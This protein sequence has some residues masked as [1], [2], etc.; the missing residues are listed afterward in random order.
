MA[1]KVTIKM[2][3]D[4][5]GV[6][7]G[8]VDRVINGR[9]HVKAEVIDR[10]VAAM[11]ELEYAP[12]CYK[13]ALA[14]GLEDTSEIAGLEKYRL[15]VLLP[16]EGGHLRRELL[17]GI[18]DAGV[19]L[20]DYNVEVLGESCE[21]NLPEESIEK[22]DALL[23]KGV[24]GIALS[25]QDHPLIVQ[26]IN[27]ISQKGIA[28]IT[29]NSDL[30]ACDRLCFVG[31]DL[32]KGGR[33]A[34]ELLG[35]YLTAEDEILVVMGNRSFQAHRLRVE[36]F[37]DR[38]RERKMPDQNTVIVE[39]YNDYMRSYQKVKEMLANRP[40]IKGIY[41]ANHSVVGCVEAV[42]ELGLTGKVH[43]VSHDLTDATRRL[44]AAG[45]I[46]FVIE[47]NIYQQSYQA[48]LKL[49]EYVQKGLAPEGEQYAAIEIVC[50]EN[51]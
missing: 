38:I 32:V 5:A 12:A 22:I 36:G 51:L 2:V 34:G 15:G 13:Q 39:S 29:M 41:M 30:T 27:E 11:R 45:E 48:L 43:I 31:Q 21:S 49:R 19:L 44:L 14:L 17:R 25:V 9:P 37:Q 40:R 33:V 8:T 10:V 20:R 24:K 23:A 7:R 28:V 50:S 16:E 26:R 3:A 35:R 4:R 1:K 18:E 42:R 46:D 6:S 47:Q